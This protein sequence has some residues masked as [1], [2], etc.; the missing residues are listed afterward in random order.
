MTFPGRRFHLQ[1]T[2]LLDLLLIVIFAQYLD[3][4]QQAALQSEAVSA[5]LAAGRRKLQ[6]LSEAQQRELAAAREQ[7]EQ[8]RREL[9]ERQAKLDRRAE[10][11]GDRV[12]DVLSQQRRAANLIAEL[13]DVPAA[14]IEQALKPLPPAAPP[15][16][17]AQIERLRR[18]FEELAGLRGTEV[19]EHLLSYDELRKRADVWT[20]RIAAN[21]E[22]TLTAGGQSQSF[23]AESREDFVEELFQRYQTLPQPKGLVVI[24]VS[25]GDARADVRQAVLRGLPTA[26]RRM[27]EDQLG[28]TQFEYAV[29]GFIPHRDETGED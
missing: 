29:L 6:R 21:G 25:Y 26:I 24:M 1:L 19:I 14:L 23:R 28:R 10:T 4:Q 7:L 16:S 20:L 17:E 5:E 12:E 18:R 13:F 8:E 27:Q 11:M 9:A 22:I 2:P 3:V 15:R